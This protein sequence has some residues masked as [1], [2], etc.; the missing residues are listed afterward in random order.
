MEKDA[1][2]AAD[3][4][5]WLGKHGREAFEAL[6]TAVMRREDAGDWLEEAQEWI[7]DLEGPPG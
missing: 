1:E 6:Q 2:K 7:Q 4:L 5:R 3:A